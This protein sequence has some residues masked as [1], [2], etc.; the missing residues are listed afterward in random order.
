MRVLKDK[1]TSF[2]KNG[3][4]IFW[5]IDCDFIIKL[6]LNCIANDSKNTKNCLFDANKLEQILS[7][8][9]SSPSNRL[10]TILFSCYTI[11]SR[12][13]LQLGFYYHGFARKHHLV[14]TNNKYLKNM[15]LKK[16]RSKRALFLLLLAIF[17]CFLGTITVAPM[18]VFIR[19]VFTRAC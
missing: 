14:L 8:T 17:N 3:F 6:I 1:Y 16:L 2:V 9:V 5:T 13:N 11:H 10:K 18:S 15:S 4:Q 7:L 19:V 12:W